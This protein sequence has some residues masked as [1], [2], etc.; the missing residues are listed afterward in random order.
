MAII[1]TKVKASKIPNITKKIQ[2]NWEWF[3]NADNSSK[4]RIMI[5]WDPNILEVYIDKFSAQH[6]T[7]SVKSLDGRVECLVSSIYGHNHQATRKALWQDLLQIQQTVVNKPWILSGD[8]NAITGQED[9]IGGAAVTEA[10]T[11][12][13]RE[14]IDKCHLSHLKTEGCHYTWNNKQDSNFRVW[15]RL[16]RALVNDSWINLH[17]SS[18]VEYLLPSC[19]DHS[20]ALVSIYDDHV[21]GKKPFKFY[22]MWIKH[23]SYLPIISTVWQSTIAGCSMFSVTSKL[24]LLKTALKDLNKRSFHNISEQ[25]SRIQWSVQGDRCTSFYH[26]A[27]KAK[28]HLNRVMV[29]YNDAGCRLTDGDEI[30]QELISFYKKLMGTT[31]KTASPV[32]DIITNGPCLDQAQARNLSSPVTKEEIKNAVFSMGDDKAPGPDGFSMAFY[33]SAWHIIGD[34][35]TKAITEFFNTGKLLGMINATSIT[36]IPKIKCPKF[37]ADF[38]PIACCNCLYKIISKILANMI[39]PVMGFLINEAQSAFVR[40]R[41]ISTNILLAHEIVKNYNRKHISPRIML[42]IDIKKAFDT[43]NWNFLKDMLLGLGFP[44]KTVNWIMACITSPK[45]SIS[46]NGT[47]HGYFKGERGLRQGDPISPYLFNLGMEYLSRQLNLLKNNKDFK[48]HPRCGDLKITHL[49]FADDLLL[50]SKGDLHSVNILY[51][52]FKHFS[53]V[54]DLEAN[55]GKCKVFYG[56]IDDNLKG[57]VSNLLNFPEGTLPITYLGVPLIGKRLSYMDCSNLFNKITGQF[58]ACL[59]NRFLSYAGRLQIIKSVVLGIQNFWTSNYVLP[60]RVLHKIDELCRNFLW[61]NSEHVH[62]TPLISWDKACMHKK[63]GGLG[64]YS[65]STWSTASA[66]RLIWNIHVNKEN[67]W[68]KWIHGTYLKNCDVWHVQAKKTDSWMWRQILKIRDKAQGLFGGIDN[69]IQTI[70]YCYKNAKVKLSDLYAALSPTSNLV[71][72]FGTIWESSNYPRHAFISWLAIQNRLL[73]QD[74]LIRRGVVSINSCVLCSGLECRDHLF[75]ECSYSSDIW[76]N[77]MNWLQFRWRSSNWNQ[78]LNWFCHRL[79]GRGF[80][81]KLKKLAFTSTIYKI[82]NERNGRTFRQELKPA[83]QVFKEI[84]F[85]I[86]AIVLNGPFTAEDREWI[87]SL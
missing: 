23:D 19:S 62:K 74:R 39:K 66:L 78:V 87:C 37:S 14:F 69:L 21:Q 58:Q 56:G 61:G 53:D 13:F 82:W 72:W 32:R 85:S 28:R 47:L 41:Q 2:G 29:L 18:H 7:C 40:G 15:S 12:D 86:L 10:E 83:D 51:K 30:T 65:A 48:F 33:K 38:R 57:H 59:K 45:Y 9:K 63:I 4:A 46:L 76:A 36:L 27:I 34:E 24:K 73:T 11:T 31:I 77:V 8:F 84:K 75:F 80:K 60:M 52:C 68:I 55:P 6:I 35:V 5:L 16:D 64:I 50:F 81:Q 26:S 49:I 1:E 79:R 17:N 25:K 70:C 54:S 71:P 3:S 44:D 43:I 22:K 42:S 20:P 67:L